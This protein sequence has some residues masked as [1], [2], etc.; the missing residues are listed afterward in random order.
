M[1]CTEA[2]VGREEFLI[3]ENQQP[4]NIV[5]S[6][7]IHD[8][9]IEEEIREAF[10]VFDREGHGFIPV[11]DLTH[12][13]QTLG[14]KLSSEETQVLSKYFLILNRRFICIKLD[15]IVCLY[16][17]SLYQSHL[18]TRCKVMDMPYIPVIL[19]CN[20]TIK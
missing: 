9:D 5:Y 15:Q 3:N 18:Q 7:E 19:L 4:S 8:N 6:R 17:I 11:P 20:Q 10:R 13:L 2:N 12:V 14:E 1:S 16:F